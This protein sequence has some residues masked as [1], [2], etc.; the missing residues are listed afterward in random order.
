LAA[1]YLFRSHL[2][3][4]CFFTLLGMEHSGEETMMSSFSYSIHWAPLNGITLG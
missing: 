3:D 1:K 4:Q 2:G